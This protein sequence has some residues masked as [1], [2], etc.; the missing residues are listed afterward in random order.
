[1]AR[2]KDIAESKSILT[3]E[4]EIVIYDGGDS[5]N[6]MRALV[7]SVASLAPVH[8]VNGEIGTVTIDKGD[9][10][11]GNVDNTSDLNKPISTATQTGLDGK[12][13]DLG[14]PA[15]NGQILASTTA[16]VRSWIDNSG[17]VSSVF[18][19]TGDV[20]AESGDYSTSQVTEDTNL[21]Y[22]EARV[23][24]NTSVSA[25]TTHRGLVTGNPHSV[26]QTEVGLGNVDN[27]S[28]AD[29][30][31][32]DDTQDALDLKVN[33]TD[34]V[35]NVTSTATDK[36]L[37]ANQGKVLKDLITNLPSSL[38]PQGNWDADTNTPNIT[39]TTTTGYFWI[40]SVDGSTDIGGITDW[41]VNDWVIKTDAGWAKVD[42][43]DKVDSVNGETGDVVLD[44]DDIDEGSTNLYYTEARVSANTDVSANTTH[45]TSDGSDHTFI[46]QDVTS[47][48]SPTFV[49]PT[50]DTIKSNTSYTPT[51]SEAIGERYYDADNKTTSLVLPYGA[52][53]QDG[54]EIQSPVY[55]NTGVK[56][57]N[58]QVVRL[59]GAIG[60]Y[61]TVELASALDDEHAN[62]TI[63]LMT[64][65]AE[66]DD[67][68]Y[69][70]KIGKVR[71]L[72]TSSLASGTSL[73]LSNIAGEYTATIPS[74]PSSVVRLGQIGCSD[75]TN[76]DIDVHIDVNEA[77]RA[78]KV[79]K[80]P[81]GF[82]EPEDCIVTYAPT[83]RT[84][85][86]TGT[87][88]AYWQGEHIH[89][90]E[91]GWVSEAHDDLDGVWFLYYD[92]TDFIWSQTAWSFSQLQIAYVYRNDVDFALRECHGVMNWASHEEFHNVI[93]TWRE[94]GGLLT[95]YTLDSTT[96]ANRRP[97][98]EASVIHDEDLKTTNPAL[99]T[100]LYAR[101]YLSLT[102][103]NNIEVDQTDIVPLSGNQPYWNEFTGGAWTQTLM[104]NN[105]Y[106]NVWVLAIPAAADTNS[107]KLRYVFIQGQANGDLVDIQN[108]LPQD[109]DLGALGVALPEFVFISRVILQYTAGNWRLQSVENLTG[110]KFIQTGSPSG[111]Y[112]S[113]V[114]SDTTLTGSGIVTDPLGIDL[115]N[116]NT[117]SGKQTFGELDVTTINSGTLSGNN[118][119]DITVTDSAEI[120]FTLTGQDLTASL[121]AGSI[122]ETKLD[123][124]VNAS[125]DLADSAIQTETD[126]VFTSSPAFSIDAGDITNLGNLSGTNT[127]DVTVTD[128][129]EIDFTL[130]GQ[131]ITA[132]LKTTTVS[133]GSYTNTNLTVDSKGR[134]TAASNGTS[135]GSSPLTTKGDIYTYSTVDA[136]LP[137][138]T[139]DQ[140]LT[141]DS[142]TSTGLKWATVPGNSTGFIT[143]GIISNDGTTP[144]EIINITAFKARS[145]DD[146]Q[147]IEVSSGSL[148]ITTNA[149]WASG[150]AP[151][152]ISTS[153][154]VWADYNSG[155]PIF[156]LDNATG[157]NI[158]GAKRRVGTF[159]TDSSGDIIPFKMNEL[160]GG[161]VYVA[162]N[163]VITD[164]STTTVP[165]TYT[166]ITLSAP[167]NTMV[168]LGVY[169]AD[170]DALETQV[171]I[172][173]TSQTSTI[174][175]LAGSNAHSM[176]GQFSF[177]VDSNSQL[178]YYGDDASVSLLLIY[179]M[180]F[181]DE[182]MS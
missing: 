61:S 146:T 84:I 180:S 77:I 87:V 152:L 2:I 123:T 12:E 119:G 75:A 95:D 116:A 53:L 80:D 30:P 103:T 24:A 106:M 112:L 161:A 158:A 82:F 153:I 18:T 126:P 104:A 17:G 130:T 132:D 40:V 177:R 92:G 37:S 1:M 29:K 6:D 113:S 7:S 44:T 174:T 172:K 149:D 157:S 171:F 137:V 127:G 54:Q 107:Q 125:L 109:V 150:T 76:G 15:S 129:S 91:S 165:A 64:T 33:I 124:S 97:L 56:L 52:L 176:T 94:S 164:L 179:I 98:I 175:T 28:D 70:T 21:Y 79:A 148:N 66:I 114:S 170:D 49:S 145:S 120:D 22:T 73:W 83:A 8:S 10:G 99:A 105:S 23:S 46:D 60:N 72:D 45:R 36:P 143:G 26:T 166:A 154:F 88:Q 48:S 5:G 102:D 81:T 163:D 25:N 74:P 93:G 35:D 90:L 111:N 138:G 144:D 11:L 156:I 134:I 57:L 58:G 38:V 41:K 13:D 14:L 122:D 131:D 69:V 32:S 34:I 39:G 89:V 31:V 43:T 135:G 78:Y 160:A 96:A 133:A 169:L 136:R 65:D 117:W 115:A 55:N 19:R 140:I 155:S 159:L 151:S 42:N 86:L 181:T 121:K 162:Y 178:Q 51:G 167:A 118:S 71:G 63:G 101:N 59:T 20:V 100:E 141:V 110:N 4:E 27:T 182:R 9:V 168:K 16:G 108:R 62:S 142:S 128:S 85:T 147:D 3:G 50:V 139:N 173:E 68:G 67:Y 47:T